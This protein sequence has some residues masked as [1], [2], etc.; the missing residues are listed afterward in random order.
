MYLMYRFVIFYEY[1][2]LQIYVFFIKQPNKKSI[3]FALY[4]S[5]TY[6]YKKYQHVRNVVA[7]M[8]TC[9]YQVYKFGYFFCSRNCVGVSP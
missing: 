5:I 7:D 4:I 6:E 2:R 3:F 1:K 8:S 9:G